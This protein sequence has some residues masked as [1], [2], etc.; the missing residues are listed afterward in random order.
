MPLR[1]SLPADTTLLEYYVAK[2]TVLALVVDQQRIQ[3]VPTTLAS[4]VTDMWRAMAA[5]LSRAA[6]VPSSQTN[7]MRTLAAS[8]LEALYAELVEPMEEMITG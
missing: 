8:H 3:V 4:T 7:E 6:V 1:S 5:D 2:G